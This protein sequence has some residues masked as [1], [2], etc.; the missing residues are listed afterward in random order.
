MILGITIDSIDYLEAEIRQ[1]VQRHPIRAV[2]DNSPYGWNYVVDLP[3]RGV[4]RYS[5]RIVNFRTV[6][7]LITPDIPPRLVTALLKV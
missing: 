3:L 2:V 5:E 1:G 7:E 6:W 4:G